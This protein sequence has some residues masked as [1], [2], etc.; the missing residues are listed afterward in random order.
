MTQK[1]LSHAAGWKGQKLLPGAHQTEGGAGMHVVVVCCAL[2]TGAQAGV[3]PSAQNAGVTIL[4]I[5][6]LFVKW[7]F[8][9]SVM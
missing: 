8:R 6:P 7:M 4:C 9:E 1:M 2:C 3:V 5:H